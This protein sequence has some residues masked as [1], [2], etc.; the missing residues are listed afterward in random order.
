MKSYRKELWFN[1]VGRR[2]LVNITPQAEACLQESGVKEGLI[3][4]N[5]M[6]MKFIKS[7]SAWMV[8]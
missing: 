2:G 4:V 5:T 3:L 1:I 8:G 7:H 6:Q